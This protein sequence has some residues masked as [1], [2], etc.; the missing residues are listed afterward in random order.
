MIVESADEP[1]RQPSRGQADRHAQ[2]DGPDEPD[3]RLDRARRHQH[4]LD[5]DREQDQPGAVIEQALAIDHR[6]ER[7]R[8]TQRLERRDHGRRVRG[9]NHRADQECQVQPKPG[10]EV[11]HDRHDRGGDEHTRH[12]EEDEPA[13]PPSQFIE[14]QAVGGLENEA[15]QQHDEHELRCDVEGRKAEDRGQATDDEAGDDEGD[16]VRQAQRPGDDRHESGKPE[17]TDE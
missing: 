14:P 17:E 3:S 7:G 11:Q 13:Q 9:G 1:G 6:C 15:G 16:R 2:R 8:D 10:H 12:G 5:R 4:G